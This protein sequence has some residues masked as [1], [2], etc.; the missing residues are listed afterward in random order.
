MLIFIT[1]IADIGKEVINMTRT[2]LYVSDVV[3]TTFF[4]YRNQISVM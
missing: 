3:L 1:V 4:V 2:N